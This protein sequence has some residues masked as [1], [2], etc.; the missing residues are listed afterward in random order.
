[1]VFCEG[2]AV[3]EGNVNRLP[4]M[5][6]VV[7]VVKSDHRLPETVNTG[8]LYILRHAK[9]CIHPSGMSGPL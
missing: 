1:M 6:G 8:W 4:L 7:F 3:A 5:G 9:T 2:V